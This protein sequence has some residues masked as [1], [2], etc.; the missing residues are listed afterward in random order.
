MKTPGGAIDR[1]FLFW[2]FYVMGDSI[3]LHLPLPV[4]PPVPSVKKHM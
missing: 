3:L 1:K 4:N 2:A